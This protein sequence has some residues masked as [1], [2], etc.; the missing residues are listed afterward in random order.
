MDDRAKPF[1]EIM[2]MT[3]EDRATQTKVGTFILL[4]L[5]TIAAMVV[6][7]GRL[8]EGV[9]GYYN[10]RVEFP[11]ASG[12]LRGAEVLLAGAMI[13]RVDNSPTMLQ[14]MEGVYVNVR[15]LD[16]VKIPSASEF[17]IGS[18]GLLGDKYVEIRLKPNAKASP[19]IAPKSTIKGGS[20][21]GGLSAMADG[22]TALLPR[23]QAA[24]DN[25]NSIAKKIDT[26]VLNE[27]GVKS[28]AETLK[29]VR[30][31]ARKIDSGVLS[32]DGIKSL[33]ETLKN[34]QT[35]SATLATASGK[36]DAVVAKVD[37]VVAQAETAIAS[38]KGTM[39]SA[40]NAADELQSALADIRGLI[41][42]VKQGQGA[43]GMLISNRETADNLR[44]LVANLK[45]Y[46]ILWYRDGE[47]AK[48][49]APGR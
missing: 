28:L 3:S 46:G 42:D 19:P 14:N 6:Y 40:K 44:S 17:V 35:T 7:F 27:D 18:S 22:A 29:N 31:V 4:G 39:D 26:G 10:L 32:E 1:I 11:N 48:N 15:V 49:P 36:V 25:I 21:G 45:R 2:T 8:G 47:K 5:I 13:G 37:K 38:G 41:R 24:V 9:R 34:L 20:D 12:L 30:D 16:D 33:S 43:L 23:L